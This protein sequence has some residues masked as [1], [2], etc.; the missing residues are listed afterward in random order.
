MP[1]GADGDLGFVAAVFH[2]QRDTLLA[3]CFATFGLCTGFIEMLG[4]FMRGIELAGRIPDPSLVKGT[5][6]MMTTLAV[7]VVAGGL[8]VVFG[9]V[10]LGPLAA[11]SACLLMVLIPAVGVWAFR[12]AIRYRSSLAAASKHAAQLHAEAE[13]QLAMGGGA[14]A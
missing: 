2:A 1:G 12:L 4:L 9:L 6:R 13:R 7:A 14:R 10:L 8:T 11:I 5:K 3:L